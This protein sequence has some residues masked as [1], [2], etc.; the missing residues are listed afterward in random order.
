[1][2]KLQIFKLYLVI[3]MVRLLVYLGGILLCRCKARVKDLRLKTQQ[4]AFKLSPR[5]Y[6]MQFRNMEFMARFTNL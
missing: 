1:M 2:A 4:K 6:R 3:F 5:F